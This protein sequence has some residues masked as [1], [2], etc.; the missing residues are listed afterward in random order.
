M[1]FKPC[2]ELK[3]INGEVFKK[4]KDNTA[5][6]A[7][8]AMNALLADVQGE[9]VP[10]AKKFHYYN[11]A[12]RIKHAVSESAEEIDLPSEDIALIKERIGKV[13]NTGIVGPA[14][15]AIEG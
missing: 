4:D 6:L 10:P 14:W 15:Q 11:L 3:D 2:L 1:K 8:F 9:T 12:S 13:Y 5:V 7:D